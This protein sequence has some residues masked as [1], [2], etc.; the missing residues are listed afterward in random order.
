MKRIFLFGFI[1]IF[2]LQGTLWA[3]FI[4]SSDTV[5]KPVPMA[6]CE[7]VCQKNTTEQYAQTLCVRTALQ[8]NKMDGFI[9]SS[10]IDPIDKGFPL[11]QLSQCSIFRS[12]FLYAPNNTVI[13]TADDPPQHRSSP[14]LYLASHAFLI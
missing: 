3:C 7:S 13:T 4:P 2:L 9:K 12:L 11:A 8:T 6:C 5:I 1:S 10:P 14:P